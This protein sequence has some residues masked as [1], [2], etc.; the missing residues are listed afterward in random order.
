MKE[1][2]IPDYCEA[3]IGSERRLIEIEIKQRKSH[4]PELQK[5]I[6]QVTPVCINV[7]LG[8]VVLRIARKVI[9]RGNGRNLGSIV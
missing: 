4:G 1:L 2:A 5:V 7:E 6:R 3:T 9:G 8:G